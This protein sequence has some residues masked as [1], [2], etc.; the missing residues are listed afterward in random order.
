M[1]LKVNWIINYLRLV[2]HLGT[3]PKLLSF[4]VVILTHWVVILTHFDW[5]TGLVSDDSLNRLLKEKT[6]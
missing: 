5:E 4:W 2:I 6:H 3:T 1:G